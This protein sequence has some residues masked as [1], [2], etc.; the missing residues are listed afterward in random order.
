M[1]EEQAHEVQDDLQAILGESQPG[2]SGSLHGLGR[3]EPAQP[4]DP[5]R[6]RKWSLD[7]VFPE[8]VRRIDS[9]DGEERKEEIH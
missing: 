2:V 5:L 1:G 6:R 3:H 8:G 7:L 4:G 9:P